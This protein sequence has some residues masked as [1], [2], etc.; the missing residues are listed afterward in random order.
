[1]D[2]LLE[3]DDNIVDRVGYR[4][5]NDDAIARFKLDCNVS[6]GWNLSP[7]LPEP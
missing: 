5:D 4:D 6:S 7:E 2:S 1:M 3:D